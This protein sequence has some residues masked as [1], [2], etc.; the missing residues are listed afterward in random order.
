MRFSPF[1]YADFPFFLHIFPLFLRT[2][3]LFLLK[4]KGKQQQFTAKMG[5]FT[6]TPSAPTPCKTSR[7]ILGPSGHGLPNPWFAF[8][9]TTAITK[10]TKV[11]KTT[12]TATNK[13]DEWCI[14]GNHGN[15]GNDENYGN[16][17]QQLRFGVFREGVFQ[18]MP[19]LEGQF[20]KEIS[21]R[22]AGENHLRTQKTQNKALRR[23]S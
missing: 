21:V 2:F 16:L 6:P 13:R 4:D 20:L 17:G 7:S 12:Q 5:N 18:K 9:K 1:F 11:A 14:R 19:A 22:F 23:G 15:T 3:P 10:T 8:T